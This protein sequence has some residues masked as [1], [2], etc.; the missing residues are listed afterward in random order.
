MLQPDKEQSHIALREERGRGGEGKR[1]R[2]EKGGTR[3][4]EWLAIQEMPCNLSV[5]NKTLGQMF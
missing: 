4:K 3:K 2:G 5:S 1:G